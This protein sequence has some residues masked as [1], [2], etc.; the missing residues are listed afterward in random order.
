MSAP[1]LRARADE[2]LTHALEAAGARD[3]REHCRA[4]LRDL[5]AR[6]PDAYRRALA[7]Y[8]ERLIPAVARGDGDALAEWLEYGRVLA[9]LAAPGR[10]VQIDPA[11]RASDYAPPVPSDALVLHLPDRATDRALAVG[12]PARLSPPQRA[13][14]DLLVKQAQG[15]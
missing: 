14:Y 5:K 11:G 3:P 7:Y 13:N 4:Q 1:D 6:S 12:L 10:T 9:T 8:E 2:R 15:L